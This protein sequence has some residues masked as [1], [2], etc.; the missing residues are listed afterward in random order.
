MR[1][2][3]TAVTGWRVG[4]SF[5]GNTTVA[6]VWNGALSGTAPSYTVGNV[7][8]NGSVPAGGTTGF[9]FLGSGAAAAPTLTC[10]SP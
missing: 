7:S 6:Q 3:N 1:A 5:A 8:W 10:A 2:G 9:G 4:L